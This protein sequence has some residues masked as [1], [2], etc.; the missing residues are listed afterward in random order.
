[1][2]IKHTASTMANR[3]EILKQQFH[4]SLALPFERVS[5]AAIAR[6]LQTSFPDLS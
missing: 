1:M 4:N 3:A 6:A 5:S 2:E